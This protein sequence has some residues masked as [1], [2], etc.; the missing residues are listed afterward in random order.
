MAFHGLSTVASESLLRRDFASHLYGANPAR[1]VAHAGKLLRYVGN[2]SALVRA[3]G[4]STKMVTST[5]PLIAAVGGGPKRPVDLALR[6]SRSEF[7]A[8]NPLE[9]V[10]IAQRANGGASVGPDGIK[11]EPIGAPA[12]GAVV[13]DSVFFHDVGPDEDATVTPTIRGVEFSTVLR[14]RQSPDQIAYRVALPPGATLTLRA[15]GATVERHGQVLASIPVPSATDA[16]NTPVAVLMHAKGDELRLSVPHRS[17]SVA[18]PVI[19][20]PKVIIYRVDGKSPYWEFTAHT[21]GGSAPIEGPEP[22]VLIAPTANWGTGELEGETAIESWYHPWS[23][24]KWSPPFGSSI[25]RVTYEG[26]YVTPLATG[27]ESHKTTLTGRYAVGAGCEGGSNEFAPPTTFSCG[28]DC[29]GECTAIGLGLGEPPQEWTGERWT[30][31]PAEFPTMVSLEALTV[32]QA[33]LP[34]R[35][36]GPRMTELLGLVNPAD[37]GRTESCVGD[38]VN[39]ATGNLT[40]VQTDLNI[41]GRGI[42]LQLERTYN[43]QDAAAGYHGAFGYGWSWTFGASL[44][45]HTSTNDGVKTET[46]TVKQG[47]GSTAVYTTTEGHTTTAPGVEATLKRVGSHYIFTLPNQTQFRFSGG[48][49]LES[50]TDR[51]GNTTTVEEECEGGKEGGGVSEVRMRYADYTT[52]DVSDGGERSCHIAVTDPSGRKMNLYLDA[53]GLVERSTDPMGH[54]VSY[55]YEEGDLTS[56]TYPGETTPRWRFRYDSHHRLTEVIDG[57]GHATANTYDSLNRVTA[58]TDRRGDTRHLEYDETAPPIEGTLFTGAE[59]EEEEGLP[60]LSETEEAGLANV[61]GS[62]EEVR[63]SPAYI[64][65]ITDEASDAVTV[66]H[67]DGE[68]ELKE[69]TRGT[70]TPSATTESFEYDPSGE[71]TRVTDGNGHA[72]GYTYDSEGNRTSETSPDSDEANWEY[73]TAHDVIATTA[74]SGEHTTIERDGH[75]NATKVSRSA[76]GGTQATEYAYDSYGELTSMTNPLEHVWKY[77]YDGDG[78]RIAEIDPEENKRTFAFNGDSQEIATT[79]PRGNVSGAEPGKYTTTIERDAQGRVVRVIEPTE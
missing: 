76:P 16:Q 77:E 8:A 41:P 47:N 14:S 49:Q 40:E 78:D 38:P 4:Q 61:L 70:G 27:V 45:F 25:E 3:A 74:P 57:R 34:H 11:I 37:P 59:T 7:V 60:E 33:R 28:G 65:T 13:G 26:V 15:G 21:E 2:S 9:R 42:G 44:S 31:D 55:G 12:P 62:G 35:R 46:K 72:T 56:V 52:M 22:G 58:Q 20:D 67:F 1:A 17:L 75:G 18:Y 73:D 43:S 23:Q 71:P 29:E 39:C 63:P 19:V 79:S 36:R 53:E 69:I 10:A 30:V 24:W 32:E 54:T 66:E 51:N 68:D 5:V 6:R 48:G 64:T 50:E